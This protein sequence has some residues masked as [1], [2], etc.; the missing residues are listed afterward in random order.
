MFLWT[1]R[2]HYWQPHWK[3]LTKT[4]NFSL[5]VRKSKKKFKTFSRKP[6][7]SNC[8]CKH[9][10]SSSVSPASIFLTKGRNFSAQCQEIIKILDRFSDIPNGK[11]STVR[12]KG[13]AHG[14]NKLL[15][16]IQC[17]HRKQYSQPCQKVFVKSSKVFLLITEKD[18]NN[19]NF[20]RKHNFLQRFPVDT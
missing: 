5:S 1:R 11:S 20:F 7:L 4:K 17:P 3:K 2:I 14:A 8:S 15:K 13:L 16:I 6:N 12:R 19:Q 10:E 18:K 9:V